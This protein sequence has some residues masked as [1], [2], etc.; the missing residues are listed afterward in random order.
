MSHVFWHNCI[1]VGDEVGKVPLKLKEGSRGNVA[2]LLRFPHD[3]NESQCK[4]ASAKLD[5]LAMAMVDVVR[6]P[7]ESIM[8]NQIQGEPT[9]LE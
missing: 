5:A 4:E 3:W 9:P 7:Q 8:F 2:A 6:Q 1:T